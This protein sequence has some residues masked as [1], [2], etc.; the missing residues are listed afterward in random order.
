MVSLLWV[1]CATPPQPARAEAKRPA[2]PMPA[3]RMQWAEFEESQR[4]PAATD[5]WF[6]ARGHY[7]GTFEALVRVTPEARE[8]YQQHTLGTAFETGTTLVMLHRSRAT[9][10]PGPIHAMQR[11]KTSWEYLRLS[12]DGAI[13][14]RGA[15]PLCRRCHAEAPSDSVFGPSRS[16]SPTRAD[17][18]G[19]PV[20]AG[21][22]VGGEPEPQE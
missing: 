19:S 5:T 7:G 8:R 6:V 10:K 9:R 11:G 4:W 1:G 12:P 18:A 2:Q 13:E 3:P 21:A 15:L 14:A 17:E 22:P 16:R 20:E